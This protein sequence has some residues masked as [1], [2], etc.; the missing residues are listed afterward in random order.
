MRKKFFF[1]IGIVLLCLVVLGIYTIYKPH[2]NVKG[3]QAVATISA[4]VLYNEFLHS[5]IAASKKW[6]GKVVEVTGIISA[7][8]EG[9]SYFSINLEGAPEGGVNCSFLK[10]DLPP[11]LKPNKGDSITIK[12]KCTGFLMDVNLVDCVVNNNN[13]VISK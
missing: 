1:G 9:D 10:K 5:E 3:D 7:V 2:H 12:G 11:G 4:K 8:G 13:P 6:V